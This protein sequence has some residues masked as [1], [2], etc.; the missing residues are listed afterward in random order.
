MLGDIQKRDQ[1]LLLQQNDLEC[2]VDARTAE[3]Q[4]TNEELV[5][6]RDRAMDASRAKS[7]FLA[8]MSH[9]IRTPMNGVIGMTDLVL[10]SELT[11]D[12]RD[13]LATVRTS[14]DALRSNPPGGMC[15]G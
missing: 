15:P 3:L 10:Y 7:A 12:Q 11:A 8:N 1:Q 2:A 14:A 5:K 6:A 9:E 4:T 13:N